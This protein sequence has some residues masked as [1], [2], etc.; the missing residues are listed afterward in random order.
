VVA[1]EK[2]EKYA[3]PCKKKGIFFQ[4]LIM[5]ESGFRGQGLRDLI[6]LCAARAHDHP[7]GMPEFPTW[8]TKDFKSFWNQAISA[9]VVKGQA[10]MHREAMSKLQQKLS[11]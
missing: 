5:E 9:T 2:N 7:G 8:A 6:H 3:G 11:A 1:G 4:P 10:K